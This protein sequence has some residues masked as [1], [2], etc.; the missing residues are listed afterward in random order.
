MLPHVVATCGRRCRQSPYL[1]V[2]SLQASR[3]TRDVPETR[4]MSAPTKRTH[5]VEI[6]ALRMWRRAGEA[7]RVIGTAKS[8][9]TTPNAIGYATQASSPKRT[10]H[11]KYQAKG[12]WGRECRVGMCQ[13]A[14]ESAKSMAPASDGMGNEGHGWRNE[15]R[16]ALR[17]ETIR[18]EVASSRQGSESAIHAQRYDGH[19]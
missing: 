8:M 5:R 3:A 9:L 7:S 17:V 11:V 19:T 10:C 15:W 6:V 12:A 14:I 1:A 16:H 18:N 4:E 13:R 2:P